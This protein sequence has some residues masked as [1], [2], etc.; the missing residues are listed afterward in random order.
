MEQLE[1][2]K[3]FPLKVD[4]FGRLVIPAE[5]KIR[6]ACRSGQPIVGVEESDG[7]FSIKRYRDV[8]REIQDH[9]RTRIPTDRNLVDELI[10]ERRAEALRE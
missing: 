2:K 8:V 9:F 6:E 7:S 1:P 4:D 10:A 5:S 3:I